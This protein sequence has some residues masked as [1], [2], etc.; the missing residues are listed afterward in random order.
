[1]SAFAFIAD[2]LSGIDEIHCNSSALHCFFLFIDP[3]WER[4]GGR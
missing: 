2:A 3:L 1:M 4:S